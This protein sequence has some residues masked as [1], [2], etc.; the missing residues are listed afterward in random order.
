MKWKDRVSILVTDEAAKSKQG[1]NLDFGLYLKSNRK[2]LKGFGQARNMI[3]LYFRYLG[4]LCRQSGF[5]GSRTK[6]KTPDR[7]PMR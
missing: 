7:G 3:R 5:Q 2:L 1:C 6:A 4:M